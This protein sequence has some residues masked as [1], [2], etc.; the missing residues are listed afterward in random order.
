MNMDIVDRNVMMH[1][2]VLVPQ[3]MDSM[4]AIEFLTVYHKERSTN[5]SMFVVSE[6][7]LFSGE[8]YIG[9]NLQ[10]VKK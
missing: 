5:T 9:G 2:H 4:P 1:R 6:T 3:Q 7:E 8:I 10:G